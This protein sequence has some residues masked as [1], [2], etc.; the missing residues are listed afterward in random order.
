MIHVLGVSMPRSGHHLFEMI[1]KN[2]LQEKF[3]YCEFYEQ[4]CCKTI[5][6]ASEAKI[7]SGESSVFMQK[8]HD[9]EFKDP[10]TVPGTHRIVQYRSPVPRA[11]SNYELHLQHYPEDTLR[12]FRD[13][14]AA[15]ALY[16]AR[17][18]KKWLANRVPDCLLLSYEELTSHPL[19]VAL[20]FFDHVAMP[21]DPDKAA[22]GVAKAVR[23]RG[24]DNIAFVYSN[25]YSHR[26][27]NHTVLANF[28]DLVIRNCP[29]YYPVRYFAAADSRNSLLELLFNARKALDEGDP[30]KAL[31]LAEAAGKQ[32]PKDQMVKRIVRLA[33]DAGAATNGLHSVEP[34]VASNE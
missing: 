5:P 25:I 19:K 14:L 28:E 9:F 10:I 31:S 17:F 24:R 29:G 12:S 3:S 16:F 13:F 22:E 7:A 4:G 26:Y 21:I 6:C 23:V 18:Y 15:E 34:T 27:A 2:T 30:A 33:M 20:D 11:L 32:D 8:S 1:L